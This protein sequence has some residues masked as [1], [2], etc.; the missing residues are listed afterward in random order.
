M[1]SKVVGRLF[2]GMCAGWGVG[3][4]IG[5]LMFAIFV[6]GLEE[7]AIGDGGR[8]K[9]LIPEEHLL[10]YLLAEGEDAGSE[11]DQAEVGSRANEVWVSARYPSSVKATYGPAYGRRRWSLMANAPAK[12]GFPGFEVGEEA[13]VRFGWYLSAK[14]YENGSDGAGFRVWCATEATG[15]GVCVFQA[16]AEI[17][18]KVAPEEGKSE[19]YGSTGA[20][21]CLVCGERPPDLRR[22]SGDPVNPHVSCAD[23]RA[24]GKAAAGE[25]RREKVWLPVQAGEKVR[26]I[27]ETDPG[28]TDRAD[29]CYWEMPA[30]GWKAKVTRKPNLGPNAVLFT[31]DTLRADRLSCYGYARETS[32]VIDRLAKNGVLLTEAY[33]QSTTTVPSHI[34]IMTSRY[35]KEFNIYNQTSNPLPGSFL[36]VAECFRGA[37]YSTGAFLSVNFMRDAWTGLGQGF[38]TF[39]EGAKAAIDGEYA[40][41][42]ATG[43]LAEN[44]GRRFFLWIHLYDCHVPYDPPQPY[45]DRFVDPSGVYPPV[46]ERSMFPNRDD[47]DFAYLNQDYYSDRYDGAV[48]YVDAQVG[49]IVTLLEDLGV[50]RN[51]LIVI[52]ADHG[53]CLG[54]HGIHCD[55]VSVYEQNAHVPLI[56]Y[57]A[58][59]VPAGK[60]NAA[61]CENIDIAPTMLDLAGIDIPSNWSGRS[62]VPVW[63]DRGTGRERVVT[64]HGDHLAVAYRTR[65]WTYLYQPSANKENQKILQAG[66]DVGTVGSWLARAREEELYDRLEDRAESVELSGQRSDVV[67]EMRGQAWEWIEVC[68]RPWQSGVIVQRDVVDPGRLRD[69]QGLGYME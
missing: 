34:S 41:S 63:S 5:V 45:R 2:A 36:T 1:R 8:G 24:N 4:G 18:S 31:L 47:Q 37:G 22:S 67:R 3:G 62:L 15:S 6:S 29:F 30:I 32:P 11:G 68:N 61:L 60:R 23:C 12:I 49:K 55:H 13:Y 48:A 33:S 7:R 69:V 20:E 59:H 38:R 46:L 10:M 16:T 65:E 57:W 19:I 40:I 27:F 43:W 42:A 50:A 25:V 51:T 54:E 9:V 66:W 26:L 17:H 39:R 28:G 58:G 14:A 53:E 44:H 64:E 52:A 21:N 35:L 56:F